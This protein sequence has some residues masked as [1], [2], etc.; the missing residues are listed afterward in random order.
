[1]CWST[2]FSQLI[3][4]SMEDTPSYKLGKYSK[5]NEGLDFNLYWIQ[6]RHTWVG[7]VKNRIQKIGQI[8]YV[9]TNMMW[10]TF[11][12]ILLY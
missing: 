3:I 11:I 10:I 2:P 5:R 12:V 8:I 4:K 1:M 9:S 7:R 6:T